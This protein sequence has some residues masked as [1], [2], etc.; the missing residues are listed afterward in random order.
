[1]QDQRII[2]PKSSGGIAVI[3]S[4]GEIALHEVAR[5]DVPAGVPYIIISAD[6]LPSDREFRNAWTADFTD[7]TGYG[8]G[9][10]AWFAEQAGGQ[11]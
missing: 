8:I 3:V 1:M 7:P 6:N 10:D 2:F 9:H 4:T 5:K 11:A